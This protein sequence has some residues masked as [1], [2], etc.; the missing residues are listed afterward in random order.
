MRRVSRGEAESSEEESGD[1]NEGDKHQ[2]VLRVDD[3]CAEEVLF[4][5]DSALLA[6]TLSSSRNIIHLVERAVP[7]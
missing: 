3:A 7:S 4:L 6:R 1:K 5:N 2:S